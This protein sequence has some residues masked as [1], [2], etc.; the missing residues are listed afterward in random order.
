MC[1]IYISQTISDA[2]KQYTSKIFLIIRKYSD[3][4]ILM[5]L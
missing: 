5:K 3:R 2:E 1:N 4:Q